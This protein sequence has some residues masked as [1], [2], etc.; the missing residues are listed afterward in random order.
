MANNLKEFLL[1]GIFAR[2]EYNE[3]I[4]AELANLRAFKKQYSCLH[5]GIHVCEHNEGDSDTEWSSCWCNSF[6]ICG[7]CWYN[8]GIRRCSN[9][10][11]AETHYN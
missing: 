2:A 10:N 9:L 7:A 11:C 8:L 1:K 5:C 6:P 3:R 4:Q